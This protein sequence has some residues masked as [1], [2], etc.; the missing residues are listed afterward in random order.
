MLRV[1]ACGATNSIKLTYA[2]AAIPSTHC[3]P[4]LISSPLVQ[5]DAEKIKARQ[6]AIEGPLK[7]RMGHLT[8]LLVRCCGWGGW[9]G[10]GD[11][12]KNEGER[13]R[14]RERGVPSKVKQSGRAT[15]TQRQRQQ[16]RTRAHL[17]DHAKE[18]AGDGFVA[19]KELSHGDVQ[20]FV[21][22]STLV[23]GWMD[24]ARDGPA[25]PALRS[26]GRAEAEPGRLQPLTKHTHSSHI[27]HPIHITAHTHTHTHTH[28]YTHIQTGVPK[29]LLD[30]Y[31]VVKAYRSRVAAHPKVK[32]FY[33]RPDN[34]DEI[35]LAFKP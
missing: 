27:T 32:A 9:G 2:N 6:A 25:M 30:A 14:D 26:R 24:G 15:H 10:R 21:T 31:P 28:I 33:E 8:K 4:P 29:T 5:D 22:L 13:A 34:Q 11:A 3:Y 23:C 35:R 19:G 16:Q 7:E 1:M 20:L 17:T 12:G 18:G